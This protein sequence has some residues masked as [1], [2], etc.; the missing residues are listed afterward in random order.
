MTKQK[1]I[2]PP[3]E[4]GNGSIEIGQAIPSRHRTPRRKPSH[5]EVSTPSVYTRP[6]ERRGGTPFKTLG[7]G[8]SKQAEGYRDTTYNRLLKSN[9]YRSARNHSRG[10]LASK[11][12][13]G[14]AH[15]KNHP[16]KKVK[17]TGTCQR[18]YLCH[19]KMTGKTAGDA[20]GHRETNRKG[21][22]RIVG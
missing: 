8:V 9:L 17:R 18:E 11:P 16:S 1:R 13:K 20:V 6:Q 4:K 2:D 12:K 14:R 7:T 10:N 15:K 21:E 19:K 5:Q 3:E 22:E